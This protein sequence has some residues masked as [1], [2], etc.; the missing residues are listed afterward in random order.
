MRSRRVLCL[1][2][3]PGQFSQCTQ[4]FPR[5]LAVRASHRLVFAWS[6][7]FQFITGQVRYMSAADHAGLSRRLPRRG[8]GPACFS[9]VCS[10]VQ[11]IPGR[12]QFTFAYGTFIKCTQLFSQ[13]FVVRARR[14]LI[15]FS[16]P[17]YS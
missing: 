4:L 1:S 12:A 2:K 16:C 11:C 3:Q 10:D 14:Y 15:S 6:P 13:A 17:G 9:G 5:V 7:G 8:P